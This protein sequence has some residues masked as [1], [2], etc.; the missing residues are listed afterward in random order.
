MREPPGR[1]PAVWAAHRNAIP[2]LLVFVSAVGLGGPFCSSHD[3]ILVLVL[4]V[5]FYFKYLPNDF[6]NLSEKGT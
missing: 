4:D 6:I 1:G 2:L 3:I 5:E